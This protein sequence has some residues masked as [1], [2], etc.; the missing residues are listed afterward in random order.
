MADEEEGLL[1]RAWNWVKS[2][3][4]T[5]ICAWKEILVWVVV[6]VL[7]AIVLY[8]TVALTISFVAE[9]ILTAPAGPGAWAANV[10]LLV[11]MV[12]VIIIIFTIVSYIHEQV[13]RQVKQKVRDCWQSC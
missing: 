5:L 13:W 9:V 11:V 12:I 4:C 6:M 10:V 3:A 2:A 7:I 1:S 8:A